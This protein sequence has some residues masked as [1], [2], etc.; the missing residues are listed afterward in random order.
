M[1]GALLAALDF[2]EIPAHHSHPTK[3]FEVQISDR[4]GEL[5]LVLAR[6]SERSSEYWVYSPQDDF[7]T[8][9]VEGDE[10]GRINTDALSGY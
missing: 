3:R 9:F 1:P 5:I 4:E 2:D 6:D 7:T 10:I 8:G